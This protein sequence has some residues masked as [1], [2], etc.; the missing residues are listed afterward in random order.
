MRTW[1]TTQGIST[2]QEQSGWWEG[3]NNA[4]KA[5][6]SP[7]VPWGF[8]DWE[9]AVPVGCLAAGLGGQHCAARRDR[10]ILHCSAAPEHNSCV[11]EG[12]LRS[13]G[14]RTQAASPS[15]INSSVSSTNPRLCC[16][17]VSAQAGGRDLE[18]DFYSP[19]ELSFPPRMGPGEE[20]GGCAW[21]HAGGGRC[22]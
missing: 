20:R 13:A 10:Q 7:E 22:T 1:C 8:C 2:C 16:R 9:A 19:G 3:K 4:G 21:G 11:W 18:A 17:V 14:P 6:V 15:S 12:A 5:N